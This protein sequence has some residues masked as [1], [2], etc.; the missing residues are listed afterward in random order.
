MLHLFPVLWPWKGGTQ[1]FHS[2]TSTAK[3]LMFT[4]G[5]ILW[6][7]SRFA[8]YSDALALKIICGHGHSN[9]GRKGRNCDPTHAPGGLDSKRNNQL[10]FP[11]EAERQLLLLPLVFNCRKLQLIWFS[12]CC[13]RCSLPLVAQAPLY[14][15]L[16][17]PEV[18]L[19]GSRSHSEAFR[20]TFWM[21][22]LSRRVHWKHI[23]SYVP[24]NNRG[25]GCRILWEGLKSMETVTTEWG[26]EHQ[27]SLWIVLTSGWLTINPSIVICLYHVL[28]KASTD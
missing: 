5:K 28:L 25:R 24:G 10:Y 15:P 12:K 1:C 20:E 23:T 14:A 8:A 13:L 27:V 19:A 9:R 2:W 21:L 26:H 17:P 7:T 4:A 22:S 18:L 11:A 6:C 3:F 16:V